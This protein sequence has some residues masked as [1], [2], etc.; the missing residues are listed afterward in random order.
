MPVFSTEPLSAPLT[1]IEKLGFV[2]YAASDCY[3]TGWTVRVTDVYPDGRS[4]LVTDNIL[5][6]RHRH[7]F[8]REDSLIPNVL[9]TFYIDPWS[10]AQVFNAGHRLRVIVSPP[11]YPRFEKNPNTGAPFKRDNLVLVVVTQKVYR[12][13]AMVF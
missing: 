8:D 3:D 13:P 11:N 1:V 6:A 9:D 12:T 10:T 5:M 4:I 2:L 7:G